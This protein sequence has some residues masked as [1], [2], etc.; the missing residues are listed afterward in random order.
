MLLVLWCSCPSH[1]PFHPNMPQALSQPS[2]LSQGAQAP[3]FKAHLVHCIFTI[4]H[5]D[6]QSSSTSCYTLHVPA[7][8]AP[9]LRRGLPSPTALVIL[10][11]AP[12]AR[13]LQRCPFP[14]SSDQRMCPPRSPR[15]DWIPACPL[16]ARLMLSIWLHGIDGLARIGKPATPKVSSGLPSIVAS[17][18]K[19]LCL[20]TSPPT[21]P[22]RRAASRQDELH[23][24]N[25]SQ[26]LLLPAPPKSPDSPPVPSQNS[27]HGCPAACPP[28]LLL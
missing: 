8:P 11:A 22:S 26:P 28:R 12:S 27:R 7:P 20:Y 16:P 15:A 5:R 1:H 25:L 24:S 18:G 21:Y 10:T 23:G 6:T 4:R 14:G 17:G 2:T 13:T 19:F 3:H 9:L